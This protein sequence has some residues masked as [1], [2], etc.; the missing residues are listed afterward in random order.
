MYFFI[1]CSYIEQYVQFMNKKN[2]PENNQKEDHLDILR[3]VHNNP[4]S[5]QRDLAESLG[6]SLGKL[7]YSLKALT[8]RGLIKILNFSKSKKKNKLYLCTYT[9]RD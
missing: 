4:N 1:D 5:S 7:N 9:Q 8:N 6:V 2:I 3:V